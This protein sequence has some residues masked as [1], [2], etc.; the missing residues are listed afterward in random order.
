MSIWPDDGIMPP[1]ALPLKAMTPIATKFKNGTSTRKPQIGECP[2]ALAV[3]IHMM[4]KQMMFTSGTRQS[5]NHY[6]SLPAIFTSRKVFMIG[7]HD[8]HA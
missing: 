4:A 3:S 8:H 1:D 7:I 5:T 6:H 2:A